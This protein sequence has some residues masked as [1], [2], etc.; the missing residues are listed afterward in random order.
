[1]VERYQSPDFYFSP[2]SKL[3]EINRERA[4]PIFGGQATILK[5]LAHPLIA[6][7]ISEHSNF[8]EKPLENLIHTRIIFSKLIFGT[9]EEVSDAARTINNAHNSV[10]GNLRQNSGIY[11]A[12][13]KY[14][15]KNPELLMWVWAT[16]VDTSLVVYD[17]FVRHL[18]HDEK[19]QFYKD[20]KRILPLLGGKP[21]EAPSSVKDFSNYMEEMVNDGKVKV[22]REAKEL[23]PYIMLKQFPKIK[24]YSLFMSQIA[25]GLLPETIRNQYGFSWNP[26]QQSFLDTT[27]AA[28]RLV[29][30]HILPERVRFF[31]R[32]RNARKKVISTK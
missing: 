11:N 7:A 15:A 28:S 29:Y 16:L 25:I 20:S 26:L 3:W 6:Q 5:Q 18:A 17:K 2:E 12:G 1:M 9:K 4:I 21:Q 13:T 30:P 24:P 19:E 10:K 32:Y 31:A 14:D 27:A 8:K 22:G 23:A